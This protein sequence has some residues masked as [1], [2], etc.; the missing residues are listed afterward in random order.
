MLTISMETPGV[1]GVDRFE[2][3]H[4]SSS[5]GGRAWSLIAGLFVLWSIAFV[6]HTSFI[7]LDGRRYFCLF[8][9]AMISMRYAWN[10]SHGLG[11]VWNVGEHVE[12]YSNLLM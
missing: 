7:A 10:L 8:D 2:D 12:G 9:D 1:A 5:P 6:L 3:T 11:L 4:A